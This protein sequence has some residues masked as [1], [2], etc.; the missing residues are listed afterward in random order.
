VRLAF[1]L[2]DGTMGGAESLSLELARRAQE[3]G[4][5]ATLVFIKDG[6]PLAERAAA[7]GVPTISLRHRRG[8]A[9]VLRPRAYAS[10]ITALRADLVVAMSV[11]R[12][13]WALRAGGYRGRLAAVEHGEL[14][15]HEARG[16]PVR[17]LRRIDRAIASATT[18]EVVVSEFMRGHLPRRCRPVVIPNGVDIRRFHPDGAR[19]PQGPL[20]FGFAGRLIE[21]KGV[22]QLI[23]AYARLAPHS[24]IAVRIAG[25]GPLRAS[26]A[27]LAAMTPAPDGVS[28]LGPVLDMP[29]FWRSVDVG[30]VPSDT[31]I[32]SFG[33]SALEAMASG[34]PAIVTRNGGLQD[35]VQDGVSGRV[36]EPGDT[37]GL[38]QAMARY[39]DPA[40]LAAGGAAARARALD[41]FSLDACLE[42]Y[43]GLASD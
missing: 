27:R 10:Q 39:L 24:A 23:E 16:L 29:S 28:F 5:T 8:S 36:T 34:R 18:T 3:L 15:R 4:H 38:E 30:V 6:D 32:E 41:G 19:E 33:M 31:F 11:N 7:Y 20:V 1:I 14:L 13:A 42:R 9:L 2:W 26:L 43:L 22:E 17:T 12:L 25:D 37:R 40:A 21:G 35:L